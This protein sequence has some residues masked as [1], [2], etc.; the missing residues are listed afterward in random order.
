MN[1]F[2]RIV[3]EYDARACEEARTTAGMSQNELFHRRDEFLVSIGRDTGEFLH[4]FIRATKARAILEVG[5]AYGYS[6]LW[7]AHA[8]K[9]TGGKVTSLESRGDKIAYARTRLSE[10]G[11]DGFVDVIHGDAVATLTALSGQWDFV[12]IDVWKELYVECFDLIYPAVR[13]GGFITAD[14]MI[15][16]LATRRFA[17]AYRTHVSGR[18]GVQTLLLP[19][20]SGLEL[21][22]KE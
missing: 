1:D 2:R 19:V 20:G 5:T 22:R 15:T 11:L 21:T 6:T 17:E 7:L 4:A 10:A 18:A 8:A 16:P 14:N 12:L 3:S 9:E 13:H